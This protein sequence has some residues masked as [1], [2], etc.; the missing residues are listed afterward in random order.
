MT[1]SIA[2][3][4]AAVPALARIAACA[5]AMALSCAVALAADP[6]AR[7]DSARTVRDA[8]ASAE[9][10]QR[11]L[12]S[13]E[14]PIREYFD[15]VAIPNAPLVIGDFSGLIDSPVAAARS[16]ADFVWGIF[17]GDDQRIQR[18]VQASLQTHCQF[19][20]GMEV[21]IREAVERFTTLL[22]Q[23]ELERREELYKELRGKGVE[24]TPAQV[25]A[26]IE[27]A[28]TEAGAKFSAQ[29]ARDAGAEVGTVGPATTGQVVVAGCISAALEKMILTR[30]TTAVL[31]RLGFAGGGAAVAGPIVGLVAGVLIDQI[32]DWIFN[33]SGSASDRLRETFATA[34]DE[35]IKELRATLTEYYRAVEQA[36]AEL[37]ARESRRR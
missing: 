5:V 31:A 6:P 16:A 37:I 7:A 34:R 35:S 11:M 23:R 10:L 1:R 27:R 13:A 3:L 24:I 33:I 4:F 26:L 25:E 29:V 14:R 28:L 9:A 36:R 30:V 18:D 19:P 2:N 32:A 8:A 15:E 17:G 20:G 12:A 21:S 22:R